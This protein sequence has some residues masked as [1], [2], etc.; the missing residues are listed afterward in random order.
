MMQRIATMANM[1]VAG[2]AN[3][4]APAKA[5]LRAIPKAFN[6]MTETAPVAAQIDR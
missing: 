6:A 5:N 4:F 3:W 1:Y 2:R